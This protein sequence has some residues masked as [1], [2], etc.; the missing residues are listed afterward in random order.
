[1]EEVFGVEL[2]V[3]PFLLFQRQEGTHLET[4]DTP[5]KLA[6]THKFEDRGRCFYLSYYLQLSFLGLQFVEFFIRHVPTAS[7]KLDL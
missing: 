6:E 1:M 5:E 2:R 7:K 3:I 4:Q